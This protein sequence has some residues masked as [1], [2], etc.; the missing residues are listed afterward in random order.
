M[1]DCKV[2]YRM[3]ITVL[4]WAWN[5]WGVVGINGLF[6][7]DWY[8]AWSKSC[9]IERSY[10]CRSRQERGKRVNAMIHKARNV[11]KG[12]R[13]PMQSYLRRLHCTKS[14]NVSGSGRYKCVRIFHVRRGKMTAVHHLHPTQTRNTSTQQ[15]DAGKTKTHQHK[16]GNCPP[17]PNTDTGTKKQATDQDRCGEINQAAGRCGC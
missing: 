8:D 6:Y 16:H 10:C 2:R 17:A 5:R 12:Q 11:R 3:E 14:I 15:H 9:C 4:S 13:W 1:C 7:C